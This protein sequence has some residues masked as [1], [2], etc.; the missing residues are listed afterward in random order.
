MSH[1]GGLR[2]QQTLDSV[3]EL[4]QLER[5]SFTLQPDW[6]DVADIVREMTKRFNLEALRKSLRLHTEVPDAPV[7]AHI[8]RVALERVLRNLVHNAIKF[9]LGGHV[10]LGVDAQE[11][12]VVVWVADTGVGI[13]KAFQERLFEPFTQESVGF[14]RS[15]EGVEIG[16]TITW[17][18]VNLLGG[19]LAVRPRRTKPERIGKYVYRHSAAGKHGSGATGSTGKMNGF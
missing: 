19:T 17:Q 10:T 6:Y 2:L 1:E 4:A 7:I 15:F 18:L 3:P 11:E 12:S 14:A 8:D 13:S 9:T 5:A 16:L